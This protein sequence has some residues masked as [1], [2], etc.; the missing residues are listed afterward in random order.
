MYKIMFFIKICIIIQ[1]TLACIAH[2]KV[3]FKL[4][5]YHDSLH[6][7]T[8]KVLRLSKCHMQDMELL[9][10]CQYISISEQLTIAKKSA[11]VVKRCIYVDSEVGSL[12]SL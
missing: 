4:R 7:L 2:L 11:S 8:G 10:L 3:I 1:C 6:I 9:F 5:D 12:R